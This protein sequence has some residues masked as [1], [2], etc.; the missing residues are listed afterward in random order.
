M[1]SLGEKP[2]IGIIMGILPG[3]DGVVKM[4]KSLG[5]HIPLN[6]TAQ[7]MYGKVM[8]IPDSAML[9]FSKLVT[10]WGPKEVAEY[11]AGISSGTTHPR[12][13]KMKLALEITATYYSEKEAEHA[14][15]EFI[16][17]FQQ[18]SAP[19]EMPDYSLRPGQSVI[20]VLLDSGLVA[21]KSEGRRLV[22]QKGVKLDG[23]TLLEFD[24]VFPHAG[25]LQVGKRRY[26]N[27]K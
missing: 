5:N 16:Q 19:S 18:G 3:T 15:K 8:S 25:I 27:V 20:E 4:S 13:A 6:S 17:L 1:T 24:V 22:E 9:K 12:D 23:E 10:R 11:E 7:D 26:I 21:S 14:Q 2:N